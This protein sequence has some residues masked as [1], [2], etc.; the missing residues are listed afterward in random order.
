MYLDEVEEQTVRRWIEFIKDNSLLQISVV[1]E[2]PTLITSGTYKL[3]NYNVVKSSISFS[4]TPTLNQ[5]I[6]YDRNNKDEQISVIMV[7]GA[8]GPFTVNYNY[9]PF[10]LLTRSRK[11]IDGSLFQTP[12]A[13]VLYGNSIG[14]P[15]HRQVNDAGKLVTRRRGYVTI[16]VDVDDHDGGYPVKAT[17]VGKVWAAIEGGRDVLSG[18]GFEDVVVEEIPMDESYKAEQPLEMSRGVLM[19]AF[20]I[21]PEIRR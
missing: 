2:S 12:M 18:L 19:I 10:A 4:G 16:L 3:A 11:S 7:S 13:Y 15:Y 17:L 20:T 21:Y 1:G 6:P 14:M 5:Y 8:S 9:N